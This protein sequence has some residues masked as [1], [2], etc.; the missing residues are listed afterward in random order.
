VLI[1]G[2]AKGLIDRA[3]GVSSEQL[4]TPLRSV[5]HVGN[6]RL[7]TDR[8]TFGLLRLFCVIS[9]LVAAGIAVVDAKTAAYSA[10][11]ERIWGNYSYS[12][13]LII[14]EL[15]NSLKLSPT[16][17][18]MSGVAGARA[19]I[20][21]RALDNALAGHG[22]LSL[23]RALSISKDVIDDGLAC[24][25]LA[26]QLWLGRFW[27]GV[28]AG[29]FNPELRDSFDKSI[30]FA[31]YEGWIM[32]LRVQVGARWF[33]ALDDDEHTKF[34]EDLRYLVDMGFLDDG[35]IAVQRLRGQS[36]RLR[37]EIDQW[38]IGTR[39]RFAQFLLSQGVDLKLATDFKLK[40]WQ[41][42]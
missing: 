39:T 29:G 33:Y 10:I 12:P 20:A 4:S 19:A 38:P 23:E 25:P 28:L 30:E 26:A 8:L 14:A 42:Y 41:H 17:A 31:P 1:V 11:A 7:A 40:P 9:M 13:D 18:C 2:R 16:L 3:R 37:T 27:V 35:L 6:S 5:G 36:D 15:R 24:Q 21:L 34:F 22:D 32:R